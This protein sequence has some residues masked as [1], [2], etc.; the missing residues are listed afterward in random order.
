MGMSINNVLGFIW[1]VFSGIIAL[2]LGNVFY[3]MIFGGLN[4]SGH[5]ITKYALLISFSI[6][7]FGIVFFV[8]FKVYTTMTEDKEEGGEDD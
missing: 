3:D 7:I 8:P 1:A 6:I 4:W 2:R 5:L